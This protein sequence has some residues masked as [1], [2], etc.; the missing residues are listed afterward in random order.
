MYKK[1][2]INNE[3]ITPNAQAHLQTMTKTLIMFQ[4]DWHEFVGGDSC[5][6]Y[7]LSVHFDSTEAQKMTKM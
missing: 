2:T 4:K 7:A 5:T 6:R 1:V 3:R